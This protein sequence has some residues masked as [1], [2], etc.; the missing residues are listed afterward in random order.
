[1]TVQG[2]S[3]QLRGCGTSFAVAML[4]G[5]LL[6]PPAAAAETVGDAVQSNGVA[7]AAARKLDVTLGKST[8]V[9]LKA[10][11]SRVAV[12][13]PSVAD[14]KMLNQ[15]QVWILG[16]GIGST[17]L[18]LWDKAGNTLASFDV[19]VNLNVEQLDEEVRKLVKDGEVRVR[20]VRDR[21]VLEGRVPDQAAASRVV[22]IVGAFGHKS[23]VNLLRVDAQ[24]PARAGQAAGAVEQIEIIRGTEITTKQFQAPQQ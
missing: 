5:A 1:M 4:A 20:A 19:N 24:P 8:M 7:A 23:V 11:I 22:E 15:K 9:T 16:A 3:G 6:G 2:R 12:G 14:V 18:V 17:N 21:V 10:P 13:N